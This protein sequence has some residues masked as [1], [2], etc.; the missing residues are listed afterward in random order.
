MGV[1]IYAKSRKA[2][3]TAEPFTSTPKLGAPLRLGPDVAFLFLASPATG[4]TS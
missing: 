1:R 3:I 2:A 4:R